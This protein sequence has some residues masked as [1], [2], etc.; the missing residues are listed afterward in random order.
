MTL[1]DLHSCTKTIFTFVCSTLLS[2]IRLSYVVGSYGLMF[3]ARN[4]C[5]PLTGL[6]GGIYGTNCLWAFLLAIRMLTGGWHWSALAFF[7]PGYCAALYLASLSRMRAVIPFMCI[8]FFILH[9]VGGAAALYALYWVI[10]FIIAGYSDAPLFVRMLGATFTAHAVGSVI[11]LYTVPMAAETWL[12]LIPLVAVERCTYAA[13]M[14]VMYHVI[15]WVHQCMSGAALAHKSK[16]TA[17]L[18]R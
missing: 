4:M 12:S 15:T 1:S 5:L 8:I 9:P 7:I 18:T 6:F 17:S 16:Q 3:S 11:W 2:Y 14:Y 10:P 13:G